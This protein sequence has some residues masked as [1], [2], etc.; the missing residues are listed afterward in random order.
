MTLSQIGLPL[1]M[2]TAIRC[3]SSVA[4]KSLSPEISQALVHGKNKDAVGIYG[5]IE[6][7]VGSP[8]ERIDSEDLVCVAGIDHAIHHQGRVLNLV[9]GVEDM[10]PLQLQVFHVVAG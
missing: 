4:Q 2:S 9:P 6:R 7:P 5:V 3:P 1:L 8:G 10:H